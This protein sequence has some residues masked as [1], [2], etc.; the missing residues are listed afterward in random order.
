MLDARQVV[1][2]PVRQKGMQGVDVLEDHLVGWIH[3]F[4]AVLV[5]DNIWLPTT[6]EPKMVG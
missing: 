4:V 3:V 6:L 2:R 1:W 5:V